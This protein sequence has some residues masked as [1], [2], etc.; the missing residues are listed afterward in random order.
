[1]KHDGAKNACGACCTRLDHLSVSLEG[2]P[3]LEDVSL[4]LHCGELTA[5]IGPNGAGKTTLFKAIL[6]QVP[7]QGTIS[8]S[9]AEGA[10]F[11][12]PVI[13]YVPQQLSIE[14]M[15]PVT[16]QDFLGAALTRRPSFLPA[17]RRGRGTVQAALERTG[18]QQLSDRRMGALSG[19]ELQRVLLALALSPVPDLLLLDEPVSGIDADGLNTLYRMLDDIRMEYDISVLLISHDFPFVRQYADRAVLLHHR[20]LSQGPPSAVMAG[21]AFSALFP[22]YAAKEGA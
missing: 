5:I 13:G 8:F 3:V 12:S 14:P 18:A 17:S 2:L 1:M 11:G 16:V 20:V 6:R 4:H 9:D 21:E 7:Y 10:R 15:A 19:G 22:E